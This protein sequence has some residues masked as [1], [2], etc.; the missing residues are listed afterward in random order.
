MVTTF[1]FNFTPMN[2]AACNGQIMQIQQNSALFALLG[3]TF[4]GNGTQTFGLPNL[5]G[6]TPVH[7]G[8]AQGGVARTFGSAF[9]QDNETLTTTQLPNHT[10]TLQE[11]QAGQ[12]VTATATATVNASDVSS[13]AAKPTAH[14]WA[15][16]L[17]GAAD[18]S[19]YGTT[20]NVAMASDAVQVTVTP[21]FR[22]TNL[23]IGAV[24]NGAAF[25]LAQPSL[26]LNFCICTAGI[27]P[28]RT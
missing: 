25:S 28:S 2:F 13:N 7:F 27:F 19:C 10:H 8:T 16:G 24:G 14:Y 3:T 17:T 9:G 22:A 23:A 26:A 20:H 5:Q 18:T 1:A 6:R 11:A 4:G 21:T 15:K 12:T